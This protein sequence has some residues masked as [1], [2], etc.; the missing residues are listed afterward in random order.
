[1]A[2]FHTSGNTYSGPVTDITVGG[3][4]FT[5]VN[6]ETMRVAVYVTG[7]TLS[8]MEVSADGSSWL[9]CGLATSPHFLNPGWSIK[10]S[11]L[12]APT[13]KYTEL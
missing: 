10:V 9:T 2:T 13:M 7:G 5:W 12:L 11:Y 8:L 6:P 1:M 3:S 4:P